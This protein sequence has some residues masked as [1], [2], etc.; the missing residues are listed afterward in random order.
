MKKWIAISLAVVTLAV[1]NS[2]R[3]DSETSG[4]PGNE[5]AVGA[6]ARHL[7]S[8][9]TFGKLIV[10][11]MYM[12]GHAPTS[13]SVGNM[14]DFLKKHLKKP[15]GI[16][17]EM[18]QIPSGG[19]ATYAAQEIFDLEKTHRKFYNT[20][21]TIAVSYIFVDGEYS[22][23]Q[24]NAKVLG[25]A[26]RNTSMALFQKT[27]LDNSGGLG[28]PSAT[29]LESTVMNH[30]AGHIMGLVNIGTPMVDNHQGQ[31]HHCNNSSCLM[32]HAAETTEILGFLLSNN[33]PD[34]DANCRADCK[35]N[36]GK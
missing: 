30:E 31:G 2:C 11:I 20:E 8:D 22:E 16:V 23:N 28:Q 9:E 17:V 12:P 5:L 27:I 6:S 14:E 29:K 32:Y 33:I 3:K 21:G 10:E 4:L 19:K 13:A 15:Q 34:L 7:L 35:A 24:G 25:I 18:R 36:G 1:I 26:Y